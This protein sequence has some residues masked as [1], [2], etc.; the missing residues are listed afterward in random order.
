MAPKAEVKLEDFSDEEY[1]TQK[2]FRVNSAFAF[3]L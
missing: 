2:R 1:D 3:V